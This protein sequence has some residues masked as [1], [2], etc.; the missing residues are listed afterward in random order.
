ME[1]GWINL[2]G[3]KAFIEN[4]P[5]AFII[6]LFLGTELGL[7]VVG[8][9]SIENITTTPVWVVVLLLIKLAIIAGLTFVYLSLRNSKLNKEPID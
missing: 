5:W 6:I 8:Y 4:F 9:S 3:K 2:L 1:K 7:Y